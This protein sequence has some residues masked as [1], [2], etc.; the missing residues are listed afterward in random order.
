MLK[1][2]TYNLSFRFNTNPRLQNIASNSAIKL[3]LI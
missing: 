2:Q 3:F 1:V